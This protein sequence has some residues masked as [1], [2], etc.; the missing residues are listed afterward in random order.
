[1]LPTTDAGR[2]AEL[3][4]EI[5]RKSGEL[6]AALPSKSARAELARL[7]REMNSYYSNLIEG[8]KTLPRDIEK[9]LK[10][11]FSGSPDD[12][13]NQMLSVAHVRA[14]DAMRRR[15]MADNPPNPFSSDFVC[16]LHREFYSHV[17]KEDWT[18]LS[19]SGKTYPLVPGELR[20]YNVEV[21]RHTPPDH[22]SL[23]AFL[24]R[25]ESFYSSKDILATNAL[26]AAA[27]AHHRLAWIHPFGD[28][29]GRVAR[30][31]SQA[32][33]I[34]ARVDCDGLWTLSRGLA[35]ERDR[36]YGT[37]QQGDRRRAHDYD[38]RGNLSSGI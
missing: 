16:W 37:L 29:N 15:M 34:A 6:R 20:S 4:V 12:R 14:E 1:M 13:R 17:P 30:L 10:E 5:F 36:Y 8:H 31:Q 24:Q 33:L 11:D 38:G 7:M 35:R 21:Q 2:L 3:S 19:E 26:V 25:F 22:P 9:A 28:G 27:A 32:A 23:P 18:T